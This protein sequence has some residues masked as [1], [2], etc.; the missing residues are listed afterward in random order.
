MPTCSICENGFDRFICDNCKTDKWGV[1]ASPEWNDG[2]ERPLTHEPSEKVEWGSSEYKPQWEPDE[3][4]QRIG[5][6]LVSG[7]LY[8]DIAK[9]VGRSVTYVHKIAKRLNLNRR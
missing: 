3:C 7:L 5:E 6:L 9:E 2:R 8:K 1:A 4:A